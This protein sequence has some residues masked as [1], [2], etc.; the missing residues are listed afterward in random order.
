MFRYHVTI[1]DT[2]VVVETLDG[3]I[4]GKSKNYKSIGELPEEI[5]SP[6]KQMLWVNPTDQ[7]LT[8]NLGIRIG[9]NIFWIL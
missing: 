9:E 5:K 8:E 3:S 2:G 4:I 7:T 6:L 1:T